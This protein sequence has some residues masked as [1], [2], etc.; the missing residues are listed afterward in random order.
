MRGAIVGILVLSALAAAP[1]ARGACDII[2]L[3]VEGLTLAVED[4]TNEVICLG[5][6]ITG[7]LDLSWGSGIG[8]RNFEIR[9][10][11]PLNPV[12][13]YAD[14]ALFPNLS[15]NLVVCDPESKINLRLHD[16]ILDGEGYTSLALVANLCSLQLEG[17]VIRDFEPSPGVAM[18][19]LPGD[20]ARP[21]EITRCWFEDIRGLVVHAYGGL[22]DITQSVFVGGHADTGGGVIQVGGDSQTASQGNLFWGNSSGSGGGAIYGEQGAY[23]SS[24]GDAFVGNRAP[25]GGAILWGGYAMDVNHAVFAGNAT[26]QPG[27]DCRVDEGDLIAPIQAMDP[28]C[29]YSS[30]DIGSLELPGLEAGD[31]LGAAVALTEEIQKAAFQKCLFLAND[32]GGGS[33]AGLAWVRTLLDS[34]PPVGIPDLRLIHNTFKGNKA[35]SGAAV[36]GAAASSGGFLALSNLWLDHPAE[37]VLLEGAGWDRLL[38]GNLTDGPGL[39]A[40]LAGPVYEMQETWGETP[41]LEACPDTCDDDALMAL[42]GADEDAIEL[43]YA[44]RPRAL[45]FGHELCPAPGDEWALEAGLDIQDLQMPDGSPPDRGLTGGPCTDSSLMDQDG[46]GVPD[47]ADCD[48]QNHGVNPFQVEN[49]NG[50]DDNCNGDVDEGVTHTYYWDHDGDGF[51]GEPVEACFPEDRMVGNDADCDDSDDQVNPDLDEIPDDQRDNDCDGTID[52]DAPGCHSAGCLATRVAPGEDGLQLSGLAP[53]GP[54]LSLLAAWRVIRRRR[55]G[56]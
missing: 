6:D 46:D 37:P 52:L 33:G 2:V 48:P 1:S 10:A 42:C 53:L 47:F 9:S 7:T 49:C 28:T 21:T 40:N 26:C 12:T 16:M 19:E 38:A 45:H 56:R 27:G 13:W 17:L 54:A 11:D 3:D 20:L 22:L 14:P 15:N 34:P 39:L 35:G 5:A 50:V 41:D 30:L 8:D 51:G 55:D 25:M 24:V 18:L 44:F 43:S 4:P 36:W 32:A 23:L 31:G 29:N